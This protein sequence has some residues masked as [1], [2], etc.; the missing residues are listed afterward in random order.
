VKA[1]VNT[2]RS[3]NMESGAAA[4][5]AAGVR[6]LAGVP[7]ALVRHE[8]SSAS[9]RGGATFYVA[10]VRPLS[11]VSPLVPIQSALL[12]ESLAA[13]FE[14]TQEWLLAGVHPFVRIQ[15]FFG[16]E[17]PWTFLEIA[18]EGTLSRVRALLVPF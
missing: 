13:P 3:T 6:T 10:N 15:V 2:Q 8:L 5:E 11:G 18:L 4:F 12:C 9:K 14:I 7:V 17:R 16:H 1:Y